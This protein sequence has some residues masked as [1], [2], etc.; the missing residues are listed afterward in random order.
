MKINKN[1]KGLARSSS[2]NS[3]G[4]KKSHGNFSAKDRFWIYGKHPVLMALKARRR[5]I[6]QILA[7][8]NTIK[9]LEEFL[10]KNNLLPK[11]QGMITMV[12]ND[13][14]K[15]IIGEDKTHQGLAIN[16]SYQKNKN[17]QD[18]LEK[19]NEVKLQGKKMPAILILDQITDPHNLGA[20]IR[21]AAAFNIKNIIITQ[22]N[23]AAE[24][25][26]ICKTSS[27][28]IEVVNLFSVT[29]LSKLI[30]DLKVF[31]YQFIGL[32]GKADYDIDNIPNCKNPALI[33][34]SEGLGISDAVKK[35]CD[36]LVK[37]PMNQEVESLNASVACAIAVYEIFGLEK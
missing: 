15:T 22:N 26:T 33:V 1:N 8:K 34:G 31:D 25:A 5:Q 17:Q 36:F 21:S 28:L 11:F 24:S 14:I 6:F 13:K 4:K 16:C 7:T 3:Y 20:I 30:K 12:E 19:L 35:N 29:N 37:I 23:S 9:F 2:K 32:D 18:L 27:G 10:Q